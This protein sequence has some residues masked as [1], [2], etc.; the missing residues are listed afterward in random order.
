MKGTTI[1]AGVLALALAAA[2]C[3]K[4]ETQAAYTTPDTKAKA[5]AYITDPTRL[6]EK[7]LVE[8]ASDAFVFGYPLVLMD[9]TRETMT[10]ENDP[11]RGRAPT[12]E[13][14]H[15]RDLPDATFTDV[16]SPNVDTLYSSAWLDLEDEPMVVSVPNAGDRYYVMQILDAWT[17]VVASPG[18]RTTG[19]DNLEFAI[20]GPDFE[21][22]IPR[23][24]KRI[25]SPTNMAWLIGRIQTEGGDDLS[26][27]HA[28][29]NEMRMRPLSVYK[30]DAPP[31]AP[32]L[33]KQKT[34][35]EAANPQDK[36]TSMGAEEFFARLNRLMA[37]NPPTQNDSFAMARFETIGIS[38]GKP[39]SLDRFPSE[40]ANAIDDGASQASTRVTSRAEKPLG[41]SVNGW[42]VLLT[43]G[44]YGTNYETRA[45]VAHL[46]LGANLPEDAVYPYA[47]RDAQGERLDGQNRYVVHFEKEDIPPVKAFWSLTAYDRDQRLVENDA[48]RFAVGDRDDLK[49]NAD[50]SIT[51][52]LQ[53][54]SPGADRESN[55]LPIPKEEFN[56]ILRLYWPRE[57]ILSGEWAP[58]P[59]ERVRS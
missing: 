53:S 18:T 30:G 56:V 40:V 3:A 46:G 48:D 52:Y 21:G 11:D 41:K 42:N 49:T 19:T 15:M 39:F 55:W 43:T 4:S 47:T 7:E 17:N 13:L 6:S 26:A 10:S 16:V 5:A 8:R 14:T 29:Q 33:G 38:P 58:P 34:G 54:E 20:V 23:G 2:G 1:L 27:V 12:N 59:I 28:I 24:V 22:S 57:P 51:L 45:L 9:V 25:D 32:Q 50:G 44:D 36:V 37:K 35:A 31:E